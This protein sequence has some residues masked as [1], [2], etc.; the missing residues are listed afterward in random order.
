MRR[1]YL[2]NASGEEYDLQDRTKVVLV[3][4]S[5]FGFDEQNTFQQIGNSFVSLDAN[6]SQKTISGSIVCLGEDPYKTYYE[7]ARF[8]SK[9]P[10]TLRYI[11]TE[12]MEYYLKLKV[13]SFEKA[14]VEYVDAMIA[15]ITF[16]ALSTFYKT[17]SA[18]NKGEVE[19]GTK[20]YDYTYNYEYSDE[21]AQTI[22]LQSDSSLPSP[23]KLT[24]YGPATNPRWSHYINGKLV[25][26]GLFNGTVASGNKL[27]VDNTSVPFKINEY[28]NSGEL[29]ADRYQLCDF[30][31]ERFMYA[32]RGSNRFS[33]SH[34]GSEVL[35]M[36]V[37]TNIE[38][39]TV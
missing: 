11:P 29:V 28:T 15:N 39:E 4:P 13:T 22:V 14:E 20:K 21:V 2:T 19:G 38:Y 35:A 5:G 23:V 36:S 33:I 34:D 37:E 8:L 3:Q 25:E 1:F 27:I 32:G 12:G 9:A 31:T 7:F 18:Y 17:L 24:I 30:S 10:L 6:Y 16:T 26:E